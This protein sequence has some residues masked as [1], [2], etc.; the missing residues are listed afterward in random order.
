MARTLRNCLRPPSQTTSQPTSIYRGLSW[1]TGASGE[2]RI[3]VDR[4]QQPKR[5]SICRGEMRLDPTIT[6]LDIADFVTI[7]AGVVKLAK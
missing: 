7:G 2:G 5:T 1:T 6:T 3:V 4:C